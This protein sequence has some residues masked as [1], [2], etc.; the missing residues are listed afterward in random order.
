M[1][2]PLRELRGGGGQG[3]GN[4]SVQWALSLD[5]LG[6]S[7]PPTH[8]PRALPEASQTSTRPIPHPV[9]WS[10]AQAV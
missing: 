5:R 9:Q 7:R 1:A 3:E 2:A 6:R 10:T 8:S 4:R